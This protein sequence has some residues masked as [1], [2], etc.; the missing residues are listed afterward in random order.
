MDAKDGFGAFKAMVGDTVFFPGTWW[1]NNDGDYNVY[2]GRIQKVEKARKGGHPVAVLLFH[3]NKTRYTCTSIDDLRRYH[4]REAAET[5]V[6]VA[7]DSK[8]EEKKTEEQKEEKQDD[9]G[10]GKVPELVSGSDGESEGDFGTSEDDEDEDDELPDFKDGAGWTQTHLPEYRHNSRAQNLPVGVKF[11]TPLQLLLL[12]VSIADFQTFCDQTG[13]YAHQNGAE[14]FETPSVREMLVF[15]ALMGLGTLS[16]MP[17]MDSYWTEKKSSVLP[18]PDFRPYMN[19]KRWKAIKRWFHLADNTQNLPRDHPEHDRLFR[20]RWF[21]DSLNQKFHNFWFPGQNLSFDEIMIGFLGRNPYRRVIPNKPQAVGLKLFGLVCP[22][23]NWILHFAFDVERGRSMYDLVTQSCGDVLKPG[24][25]LFV[26]RFYSTHDLALRLLEEKQVG[27]CGTIQS[28][29]IKDKGLRKRL[30][31]KPNR[32]DYVSLQTQDGKLAYCIWQDKGTV[33]FITTCLSVSN[34][35]VSR[36]MRDGEKKDIPAP[37]VASEFNKWMGGCDRVGQLK[38]RDYSL[39][40]RLRTQKWWF[41]GFLGCFDLVLAQ[42]YSLSRH[43]EQKKEHF[44]FLQELFEEMLVYDPEAKSQRRP[45]PGPLSIQEHSIGR[46]PL[47]DGQKGQ[48]GQRKQGNCAFC[49]TKAKRKRTTYYCESC[50]A[51]LCPGCFSQYDHEANQ[52][53]KRAKLFE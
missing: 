50:K 14:D 24:H 3:G 32:G 52:V 49:S 1:E 51:P 28:N 26:D 23:S 33:S 46:L 12:L 20:L 10:E 31:K 21:I 47:K 15:F 53:R 45:P 17:R 48:M 36:R 6:K 44:D 19:Q 43:L 9:T 25:I 29:R 42:T 30:P 4:D 2:E 8:M 38:T 27:L 41:K 18:R 35:P 37:E 7:Q 11:Y 22:V 5:E 16:R 13:L 40:R 34:V 39:A